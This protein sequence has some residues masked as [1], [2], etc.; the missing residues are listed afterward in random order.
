[1]SQRNAT[2]ETGTITSAGMF[3]EV[4]RH[5]RKA[6]DYTQE[7][8]ALDIPCDRSLVTRVESATRVP[9]DNFARRCDEL[10]STGGVLIK[11][12]GKVNWYPEVEHP[13]W[14]QR[15]VDMDAVAV[16]LHEYQMYV[17]P[18]LLQTE[19]YARAILS[20]T[21]SGDE[22][23]ERLRARLS[24][25][26]RFLA[27]D[28]PLYHVVLDE[29]SLRNV[30]GGAAVM[31]AQLA[32]LLDVG[33]LPNIRI[34]VAPSSL[35]GLQRPDVSM[36][37][38]KLPDGREW[39]YSESLDRGHFISDPGAIAL[40]SRTYDVLRAD[41]LSAPMSAAWISEALEGYGHDGETPSQRGNV[42]QEQLQRIKRRQLHRNRPRYPRLRPRG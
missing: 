13:D 17:V 5:F 32:H 19:E 30:V 39:I 24:R 29:S 28:G 42:D 25:Q 8:L 34:Q 35:G 22:L 21:Y 36:S 3:G 7:G 23:I 6:A 10:L 14:F 9:Q 40:H 33:R 27:A 38:I 31:R 16:A 20:Y 18:G 26:Q 2:G 37:L 1:M 15:R 12:W 41:T 4:L 11:L